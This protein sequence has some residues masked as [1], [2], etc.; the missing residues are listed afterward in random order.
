M[1]ANYIKMQM[2]INYEK[3]KTYPFKK[4]PDLPN[5]HTIITITWAV[6]SFYLQSLYCTW[7]QFEPKLLFKSQNL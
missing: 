7:L 3:I 2:T 5:T 4:C 1:F 6:S